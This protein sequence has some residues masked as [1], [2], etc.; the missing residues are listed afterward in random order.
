VIVRKLQRIVAVRGHID[1]VALFA[2][3]VADELRD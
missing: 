1:F 3:V 2:Q